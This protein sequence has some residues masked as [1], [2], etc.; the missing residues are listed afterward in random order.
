M[1]APR[2]GRASRPSPAATFAFPHTFAVGRFL[3]DWLIWDERLERAVGLRMPML[4]TTAVTGDLPH[5]HT[6]PGGEQPHRPSLRAEGASMNPRGRS[7]RRTINPFADDTSAKPQWQYNAWKWKN[8][9]LNPQKPRAEPGPDGL[10]PK[11]PM[12]CP[13]RT[14]PIRAPL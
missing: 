7:L 10:S 9:Q 2:A 12:D 8:Y 6:V 3:R 11:D 1:G 14:Q 4:G 13:Q 5:A